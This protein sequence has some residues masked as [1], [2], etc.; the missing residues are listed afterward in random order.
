MT[1]LGDR[2]PSVFA[3]TGNPVPVY[4]LP[5][6]NYQTLSAKFLRQLH[7]TTSALFSCGDF[8]LASPSLS[9]NHTRTTSE[10]RGLYAGEWDESRIE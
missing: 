8:H 3:V 9:G 2:Q 7:Q 4:F 5:T 6:A 10:W 1:A